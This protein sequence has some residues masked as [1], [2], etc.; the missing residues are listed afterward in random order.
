MPKLLKCPS[1]NF[2]SYKRWKPQ[3][4]FCACPAVAS[5]LQ[6]QLQAATFSKMQGQIDRDLSVLSEYFDEKQQEADRQACLSF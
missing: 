2:L 5:R 1:L 4:A 3:L 6:E